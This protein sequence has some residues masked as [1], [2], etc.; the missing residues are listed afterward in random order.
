MPAA[1]SF[2]GSPTWAWLDG[3]EVIVFEWTIRG[4]G[5]VNLYWV[6]PANPTEPTPITD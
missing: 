6:D 5:P 2:A 3:R 1:G 4:D